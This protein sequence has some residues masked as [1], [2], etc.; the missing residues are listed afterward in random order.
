MRFCEVRFKYF[1]T[2]CYHHLGDIRLDE[3]GFGF[4]E[5]IRDRPS[6]LLLDRLSGLL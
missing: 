6:A 4:S 2:L 3:S 1:F 5:C